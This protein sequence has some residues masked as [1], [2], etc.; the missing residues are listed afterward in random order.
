MNTRV[1]LYRLKGVSLQV[2]EYFCLFFVVY[3]KIY[4]SNCLLS[5]L[6]IRVFLKLCKSSNELFLCKLD[7]HTE[8][9]SIIPC[10]LD[11]PPETRSTPTTAA[12]IARPYQEQTDWKTDDLCVQ[13]PWK[14]VS[15]K[16]KS[17][18]TSYSPEITAVII[19]SKRASLA[20]TKH[21]CYLNQ[22]HSQGR[23]QYYTK[24]WIGKRK[25]T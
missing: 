23:N 18:W 16:A 11:M 21:H 2:G 4:S 22:D 12:P 17:R 25:I 10:S 7:Q 15:E 8:H 3:A 24:T 5:K 20:K 13:R 1:P 9:F 14:S 19:R 6:T